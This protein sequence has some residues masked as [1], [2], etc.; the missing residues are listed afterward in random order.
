MTFGR[1]D[2][3]QK[4]AMLREVIALHRLGREWVAADDLGSGRPYDRART[5][6][7]LVEAGMLEQAAGGS[8]YV[9]RATP[10]GAEWVRKDQERD[11]LGRRRGGPPID[12]EIAARV[13]RLTAMGCTIGEVAARVGLSRHTVSMYLYPE[14]RKRRLQQRRASYKKGK[15]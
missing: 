13:Q 8:V 5:V 1:K 10:A 7:A 11:S 15:A 4:A 9:Y 6:A 3:P 12:P 14:R 2:R